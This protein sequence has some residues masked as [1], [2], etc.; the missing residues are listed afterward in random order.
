MVWAERETQQFSR[1]FAQNSIT[2]SHIAAR[3]AGKWVLAVDSNKKNMD[4]DDQLAHCS[5]VYSDGYQ[6][7]FCTLLC[8]LYYFLNG[9]TS[10]FI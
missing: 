7:S 3:E 6:T 9:H 2:L 4:F 5:K 8:Q 10:N 1:S